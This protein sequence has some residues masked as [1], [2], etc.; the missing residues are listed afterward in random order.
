[1]YYGR[2]VICLIFMNIYDLLYYEVCNFR[3]L[4]FKDWKLIKIGM[5]IIII[6]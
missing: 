1:M 3:V 5:K 6:I 2:V 4:I